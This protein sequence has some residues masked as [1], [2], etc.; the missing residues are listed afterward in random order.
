MLVT[1]TDYFLVQYLVLNRTFKFFQVLLISFFSPTA[2]NLEVIYLLF[3]SHAYT[4]FA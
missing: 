1:M 4:I 3:F 2:I